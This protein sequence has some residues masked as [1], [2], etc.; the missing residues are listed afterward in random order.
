[1]NQYN[2][3]YIT[4]MSTRR[5]MTV[6]AN[7]EQGAIDKAQLESDYDM[8]AE[9]RQ[10][11]PVLKII[12]QMDLQPG[13]IV[14]AHGARFEV[15]SVT[16]HAETDPKRIAAGCYEYKSSQAKWIDGKVMAGYF[17]PTC[18]PW[19]FQGNKKATQLIEDN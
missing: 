5:T 12:N 10:L 6:T 7:D 18:G 9:V 11:G 1:M 4:V 13:M 2:V 17:G 19:N 3:T 8:F 15:L 16:I 14:H